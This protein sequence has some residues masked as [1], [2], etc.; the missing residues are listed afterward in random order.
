MS[1]VLL[2]GLGAGLGA[3]LRLLVAVRL[4]GRPGTLAVN[5]AG[6]LLLG[7]LAARLAAGSTALLL[8]GAGLCGGL[9]TFSAFA[10]EAVAPGGRGYAV[11]TV[12]G[13]L[14]LCACGLLVG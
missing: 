1:T 13:C 14:S 6:S 3:A 2:V 7:V 4:P 5:L 10:V 9:T 8:L 11:L 12:V